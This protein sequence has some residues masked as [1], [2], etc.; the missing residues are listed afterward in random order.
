MNLIPLWDSNTFYL[1]KYIDFDKDSTIFYNNLYL[2][3][4]DLVIKIPLS[5]NK[6]HSDKIKI[7][8]FNLAKYLYLLDYD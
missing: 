8:K 6:I 1:S 3:D 4:Y 5:E 7:E 2:K